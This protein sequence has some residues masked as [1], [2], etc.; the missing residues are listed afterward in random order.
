ME[1]AS[2]CCTGESEGAPGA[3]MGDDHAGLACPGRRR[4]ATACYLPPASMMT[5]V[6]VVDVQPSSSTPPYP[7][8]TQQSKEEERSRIV[9]ATGYKGRG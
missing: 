7:P 2:R 8:T 6:R 4:L 5:D 3:R 9:R 1:P